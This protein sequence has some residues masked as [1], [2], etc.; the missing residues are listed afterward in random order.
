MNLFQ[1]ISETQL[2]KL[3]TCVSFL[4]AFWMMFKLH[5]GIDEDG[6]L[7]LEA[8]KRIAQGS[9][10]QAQQLYNWPLFPWLIAK[11]SSLSGSS[12]Y[13][14]ALFLEMLFFSMATYSLLT[15]ILEAGGNKIT[16]LIAAILLFSAQYLVGHALTWIMRDQGFWAFYLSGLLFFIRFYRSGK[17]KDAL[18]WQISAFIAVFFRIE[19][20]SLLI[21][22]PFIIFFI[23]TLDLQQR[24]H[25]FLKANVLSLLWLVGYVCSLLFFEEKITSFGRLSE[26]TQ[27]LA[28]SYHQITSGIQAKSQAFAAVALNPT[29]DEY[30]IYGVLFSMLAIVVGNIISASG[31]LTAILAFL[32]YPLKNTSIKTDSQTVLTWTGWINLINIIGILL[33][34]SLLV[35][36]YAAGLAFILIIFAAFKTEA[37]L[38]QNKRSIFVA[39]WQKYIAL[40]FMA[41]FIGKGLYK[42]FR[43]EDAENNYR[44][45]AVQW[46]SSNVTPEATVFYGDARLRYYA[47]A[48][49]SGREQDWTK[50]IPAIQNKEKPYDYLVLVIKKKQKNSQLEILKQLTNYQAVK[51]IHNQGETYVIILKRKE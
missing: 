9:F 12:L 4:L 37:A 8:A 31:A 47:N 39:P 44:L 35:G 41:F 30:A 46:M 11:V 24:L 14:A 48:P 42:N 17:M 36:R 34:T 1:K 21:I 15:L 49:W 38:I 22:L 27:Y 43:P 26:L 29:N 45:A 50:S 51:E 2:I 33:T 25:M 28:A 3:L 20:V 23:T 18:F 5:G 10:D 16:V 7:Y 40:F 13:H 6:V 32:P 19:A